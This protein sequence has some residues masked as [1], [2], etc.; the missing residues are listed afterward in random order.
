MNMTEF[1]T[2]SINTA[3]E[4]QSFLRPYFHMANPQ[5]YGEWVVRGS[6]N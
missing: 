6:Q 5:A 2:E 3:R 4:G 1:D